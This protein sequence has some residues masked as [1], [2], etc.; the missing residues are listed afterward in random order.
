MDWSM[1]AWI[2]AVF[3]FVLSAILFAVEILFPASGCCRCVP[4]LAGGAPSS[5]LALS[6]TIGVITGGGGAHNWIIA[7][8]LPKHAVRPARHSRQA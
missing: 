8:Y 1:M 7:P 6:G 4:L 2:F 5:S 3:L